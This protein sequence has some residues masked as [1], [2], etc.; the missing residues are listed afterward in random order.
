MIN[1]DLLYN[2]LKAIGKTGV[3]GDEDA[4]LV[5]LA[6]INLRL[7]SNADPVSSN[8]VISDVTGAGKDFIVGSICRLLLPVNFYRHYV[9]MTPMVFIYSYIDWH[10]VVLHVEDPVKDLIS[11]SVFKTVASGGDSA[12]VVEKQKTVSKEI[13]GKPVM[14]VTSMST[15]LDVEAVRR[16]D[17]LSLDSSSELTNIV[18]RSYG[19]KRKFSKAEQDAVDYVKSLEFGNVGVPFVNDILDALPNSLVMR[20]L[21]K[22]L[23]DYTKSSALL[24][25]R[26]KATWFDY[27]V[28]RLC[29]WKLNSLG[30]V[31]LNVVEKEFVNILRNADYPMSIRDIG[32]LFSKGTSG[33][34][35][36][37]KRL[38]EFDIIEERYE[39]NVDANKEILLISLKAVAVAPFLPACTD[40]SGSKAC[41][42]DFKAFKE[43]LL[44]LDADRVALGLSPVFEAFIHACDVA[45]LNIVDKK[46]KSVRTDWF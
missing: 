32:L 24:H 18:L 23:L 39:F 46:L 12:F 19:V 30:A 9:Y 40:L 36:C 38:K 6:K 1:K 41:K 11:G 25:G 27:E 15:L 21:F 34:Y 29:F 16:W 8:L 10:G 3:V 26:K 45:P 28:A 37:V 17:M 2:I 7:V 5:L 33:A 13:K 31:P 43:L 35:R 42:R 44:R 22:K 20:T 4:I 14:L